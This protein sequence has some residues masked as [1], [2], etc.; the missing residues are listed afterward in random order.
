[1]V[2]A[3]TLNEYRKYIEKDGALARRFQPV[4]VDEPTVE[5]TI[6]ILRGLKAKYEIH[7]G[8]KILD[9]AIVASA[10]YSQRYLTER[11]M[12]DKA[13]DLLDEAASRLRM[14]QESKPDDISLLER[15]ILFNKIELEAIKKET[16]PAS[17]ERRKILESELILKEDEVGKKIEVW[18]KERDKRNS[19]NEFK[20]SLDKLKFQ[21]EE[22][23]RL[24]KWERAGQLKYQEIPELQEKIKSAGPT[25]NTMF[26]GIFLLTISFYF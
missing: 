15:Q 1:M 9:S 18:Q 22:A 20:V 5:E 11:K 2:G 13:V 25:N 10:T 19:L 26:P 8:V 3:T 21:L 17:I 14:K 23:T 6:S 4:Y 12:P 16:D 7:H 24:G